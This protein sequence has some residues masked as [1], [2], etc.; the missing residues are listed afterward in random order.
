[1][2]VKN[3]FKTILE[4]SPTAIQTEYIS[5][6]KGKIVV[7]DISLYL[8]RFHATQG[9]SFTG[10]YHQI[11]VL[12]NAQITPI[13]VFDGQYPEEKLRTLQERKKIIN[14]NIKKLRDLEENNASKNEIFKAKNLGFRID[15]KEIN[16]CKKLF[17]ILG[18]PW[19]QAKGEADILMANMV[20][21]GK[22]DAAMTEDGDL[23][24]FGCPV[25]WKKFK[26]N[27]VEIVTLKETL[28][29]LNMSLE[30][31]QQFCILSGCDYIKTI[32]GIGPKTALKLLQQYSSIDDILTDKK[33]KNYNWKPVL[34]IFNT[35]EKTRKTHFE[36]NK[37][38]IPKLVE[39]LKKNT[40]LSEK[41]IQNIELSS[42]KI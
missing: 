39:F 30:L 25:I 42:L 23:L 6:L 5:N 29:G 18:V 26:K 33:I 16:F 31:F 21:Q 27:S 8:H 12:R 32:K 38:N 19:L 35:I 40:E 36:L 37:S 4:N 11:N 2:G 20:I 34:K 22:A 15:D 17:N 9:H 3:L 41:R 10:L 7:I 13:Y 24:A 1:M 28:S 14:N